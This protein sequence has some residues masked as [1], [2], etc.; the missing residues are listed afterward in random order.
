ME[1]L[2]DYRPISLCNIVYKVLSKAI[3]NKIK[4]LLPFVILGEKTGFVPNRSIFDA[5][6][7]AQEVIHSIQHNLEP[8]MLIKLDI[9]KAYDKVNW[10]FL[11]KCMEDFGFAKQCINLIFSCISSPRF[12]ILVNKSPKGYFNISRGLRQGDPISPFLFII[13]AKSF[14]GAIGK[15]QA[16]A[17]IR[18]IKV[19]EG[20]ANITHQQFVEDIMLFS[21]G[22]KEAK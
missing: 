11:C 19:I 15:A 6:I 1:E 10:R 18:G 2:D 17:K 21:E 13:I 3:T 14:G 12:L 16:Q 20:V 4:K 8:S 5:V 7:I 22:R 9:K